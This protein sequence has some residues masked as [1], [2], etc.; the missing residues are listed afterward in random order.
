M[1]PYPLHIDACVS[2]LMI[3]GR[4][5]AIHWWLVFNLCIL[6]KN[7][8]PL[9]STGVYPL[10][11][12]DCNCTSF[13]VSKQMTIHSTTNSRENQKRCYEL[14][15]VLPG[16]T[17]FFSSTLF[18]DRDRSASNLR[19]LDFITVTNLFWSRGSLGRP[20]ATGERITMM[21]IRMPTDFT[22]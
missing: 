10:S 16:Y 12:W 8:D 21:I 5:S 11:A 2:Q 17:S 1:L 15:H 19:H 7:G 9:Y 18:E 13:T 3:S 22:G 6:A 20:K 14:S 4:G